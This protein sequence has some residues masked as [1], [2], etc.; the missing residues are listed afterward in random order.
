MVVCTAVLA[1]RLHEHS[2]WAGVGVFVVCFT[3]I[4]SSW[5]SFVVYTDL[6]D[7]TTRIATLILAAGLIGMMAAALGDL[8]ERANAFAVGFVVCRVIAARAASRTGRLLT[9]WPV[10]QLGGLTTPWIV[11]LGAGRPRSTGSG[12]SRWPSS[13]RSRRPAPRTGTRRGR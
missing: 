8:D 12:R 4:W 6:A 9:S 7:E 11:S 3:A 13:W 2:D 5:I 1:E 10:V